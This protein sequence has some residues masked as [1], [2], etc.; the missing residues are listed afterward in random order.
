VEKTAGIYKLAILGIER[1]NWSNS[2][3]VP[4]LSDAHTITIVPR[5]QSCPQ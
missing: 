2:D 4:P 5:Y 1:D 3:D